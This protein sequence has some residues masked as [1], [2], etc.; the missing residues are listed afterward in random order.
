VRRDD[1]LLQQLPVG[2]SEHD[3]LRRFLMIFQ[4][5]SDSVLEQIDVLEHAFD[6][7]V[8]PDRM[9]REMGRWLGVDWIDSSLP[10]EVQRRV[11]LDYSEVLPWR[12]TA[13]GLAA[14]LRI[15][16]GVEEV[17]VDDSGGVYAE[18]EAP[19]QA[20]HVDLEMADA[21]W[22]DPDDIV[23]IVRSELPAVVTFRLVVDGRQVW[24][25]SGSGPG[26]L[27]REEVH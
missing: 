15:M 18:G 27:E 19:R 16:S 23:R 20:P 21:G 8:A 13:R 2:M 26:Q 10:D 4:S 6:P 9:V 1:W 24:P 12:G 7:T 17:R 14:L 25:E 11:V 3:F 22:A 5:I